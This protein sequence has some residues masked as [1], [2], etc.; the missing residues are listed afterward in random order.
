MTFQTLNRNNTSHIGDVYWK[1]G[2]FVGLDMASQCP[3]MFE[4]PDLAHLMKQAAAS[5]LGPLQDALSSWTPLTNGT[6]DILSTWVAL[7]KLSTD[8]GQAMSEHRPDAACTIMVEA[9]EK[10]S[11][12]DD[13]VS[14]FVK[15]HEMY[16]ARIVGYSKNPDVFAKWLEN[17]SVPLVRGGHFDT[18]TFMLHHLSVGEID[19]RQQADYLPLLQGWAHEIRQ[20]LAYAYALQYRQTPSPKEPMQRKWL[21]ILSTYD[22]TFA[23]SPLMLDV[24]NVTGLAPSKAAAVLHDRAHRAIPSALF[25]DEQ[26]VHYRATEEDLD[27]LHIF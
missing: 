23:N 1:T 10:G 5:P 25:D 27:D 20:S 3:A 19:I 6:S 24:P 11:L 17:V 12:S 22:L 18:L 14:S 26:P 8:I 7:G 4:E 13:A 16:L 15:D 9:I 21:S 2:A